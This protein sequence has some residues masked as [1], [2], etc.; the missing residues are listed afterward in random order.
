[1]LTQQADGTL[2]VGDSHAVHDA[3]PPFMD[4]RWSRILLDEVAALLG[5]A[6][7]DV[8]ERWQGLYAT[9]GRQDILRAQ[10]LPGVSVVSVTKGVGMTVGL[11]LGARTIAAL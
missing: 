2:L 9:S 4:E 1:M 10:S 5:T 3:A 6:R 11:A 7:L 8:I